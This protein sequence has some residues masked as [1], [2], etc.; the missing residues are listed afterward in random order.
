VKSLFTLDPYQ[1]IR[2]S[3]FRYATGRVAQFPQSTGYVTP[4]SSRSNSSSSLY[5]GPVNGTPFV[6]SPLVPS[7]PRSKTSDD[8]PSKP[9][10]A[11][12]KAWAAGGVSTS[13]SG[14]STCTL[15]PF[16]PLFDPE[17]NLSFSH[18]IHRWPGT[19]TL[20][21]TSPRT[22]LPH[23]PPSLL[24]PA[25]SRS[26]LL[27]RGLHTLRTHSRRSHTALPLPSSNISPARDRTSDPSELPP[28][29][30][31]T[32]TALGRRRRPDR[33]PADLLHRQRR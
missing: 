5:P 29:P 18:A 2:S 14:S 19:I 7:P 12:N 32:Q 4:G 21:I 15:F 25:A 10:A 26:H 6:P 27:R 13:A 9:P 8:L 30:P 11:Q 1:F 28:R 33:L 22:P 20:T 23:A 3:H 16:P 17:L 31:I 24:H